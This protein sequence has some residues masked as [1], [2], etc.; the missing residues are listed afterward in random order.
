[1]K[2]YL[3][4]SFIIF[5]STACYAEENKDTIRKGEALRLTIGNKKQIVVL[6]QINAKSITAYSKDRILPQEYFWKDIK[7]IEQ[8]YQLARWQGAIRGAGVGAVIGVFSGLAI[9]IIA[10]AAA[11]PCPDPPLGGDFVCLNL[12]P[13]SGGFLGAVLFGAT[14]TII[15]SIFGSIFPGE[16]WKPVDIPF[17]SEITINGQKS[18]RLEMSI[19]L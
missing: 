15:G 19:P 13:E 14:G 16:G 1:M 17:E 3:L 9:G 6:E 8:R 12:T 11:E 10:G 2:R 4:L 5:C 18:I 7:K